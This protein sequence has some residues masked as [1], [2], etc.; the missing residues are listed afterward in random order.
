MERLTIPQSVAEWNARGRDYLPGHL[1]MEV[2]AVEAD[3]VRIRMPVDRRKCAW[4]GFL[5]AGAIVSLA[6]TS[7]GYATVRNLPEDA[8]GFTTIELKSNF[9]GTVLEGDVVCVARPAHRGRTTQ[10]WDAEVRAA[11]NGRTIALFR[12]T[13]M[14]L[15]ARG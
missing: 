5:H 8:Q 14:I 3:E 6:D 4:N 13:Q 15:R 11:A 2:L 9:L 7:C 10:V 1:E 12:C